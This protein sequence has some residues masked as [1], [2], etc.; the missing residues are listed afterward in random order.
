MA[1]SETIIVPEIFRWFRSNES[2][3]EFMT[4]SLNL[5]NDGIHTMFVEWPYASS[6][7]IRIEDD[8]TMKARKL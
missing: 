4:G 5:S 8:G 3:K 6:M 1:T 2:S 7:D